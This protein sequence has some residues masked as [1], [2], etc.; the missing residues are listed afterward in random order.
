M[1][2]DR[3]LLHDIAAELRW[4]P[5]VT[6]D[7]IHATV[8]DGVVTLSGIASSFAEKVA[9][10]KVARRISG[11]RAI[12][13]EIGVGRV[14]GDDHD[15]TGIASKVA[16]ILEWNV[17]VPAGRIR[18]EVEKGVVTL[19]GRVDW[20]FQSEAARKAVSGL[21][22]V[23][24]I[25]N[26]LEIHNPVCPGDIRDGIAAAYQRLAA[27][28]TEAVSID[29]DGSAVVLRGRVGSHYERDVAERAAWASP[30]VTEVRNDIVVAA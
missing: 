2:T 18:I 28:D 16:S 9:A 1:R 29:T 8:S 6:H 5:S 27:L 24:G 3:E 11:V 7:H 14:A 17:S 30:G 22:G 19:T 20:K 10:E 25:A 12:A 13:D 23:T 21:S 4:E 26:L 15:D